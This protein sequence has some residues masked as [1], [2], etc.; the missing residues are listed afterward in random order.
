MICVRVRIGLMMLIEMFYLKT[1][2]LKLVLLSVI[3][4]VLGSIKI[5]PES[6][7]VK[8]DQIYKEAY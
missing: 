7:Y 4:F 8:F 1:F 6:N 2:V 3:H 5:C